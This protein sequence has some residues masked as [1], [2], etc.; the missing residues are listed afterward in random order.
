VTERAPLAAAKALL[1]AGRHADAA[2]LLASSSTVDGLAMLTEARLLAG[3]LDGARVAAERAVRVDPSAPGIFDRWLRLRGDRGA[4]PGFTIEGTL[5]ARAST[6]LSLS[7]E[8]G[9]GGSA[10]VFEA[11]DSTLGRSVALK[12]LH[13]PRAQRAQLARE[14]SALVEVAGPGVPRLFA[15][16]A[17][18]GWLQLE[19]A[20]GG[21][22]AAGAPA[23]GAW[24]RALIAALARVHARGL[25]H[26]DIKPSNV[27]FDARGAPLLSDFGLTVRAGEP[28]VGAT[29]GFASPERLAGRPAH[30][31]DDVFALG[32]TVEVALGGAAGPEHLALIA[33][34]TAPRRPE[35]AR[36]L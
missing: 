2:R 16:N 13:A 31:D 33:R 4:A 30:P 10:A 23:G 9:R 22:L 19:W 14:A 3:D 5:R 24:V 8:V 28:H 6:S 36:E 27:L 11:R 12:V 7:R 29:P 21:S 15:A 25:V 26:G 35:S 34:A 18:E 1:Q 32:R 17:S 20:A